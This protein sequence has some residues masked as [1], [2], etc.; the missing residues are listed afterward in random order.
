MLTL[1][2]LNKLLKGHT[3]TQTHTHTHT[4]PA[5]HISTA[6]TN[7]QLDLVAQKV[8]TLWFEAWE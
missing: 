2:T 5:H 1:M 3:Q 4:Q 6:Y 7:K 8:L